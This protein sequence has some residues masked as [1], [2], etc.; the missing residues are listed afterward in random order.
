[1]AT[2]KLLLIHTPAR[3]SRMAPSAGYTLT[4]K[5]EALQVASTTR[6]PMEVKNHALRI[7]ADVHACP[8]ALA[9]DLG[10]YASGVI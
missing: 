9:S 5:G 10:V 7:E 8:L 2:N 4:Y 3:P 1:M 6:I